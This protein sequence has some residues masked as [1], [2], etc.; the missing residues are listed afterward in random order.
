MWPTL[1]Q[2]I[3]RCFPAD[4]LALAIKK[5][6]YELRYISAGRMGTAHKILASTPVLPSPP[7]LPAPG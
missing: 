4:R 2:N 5:L 7:P 6:Q 3:V 1:N